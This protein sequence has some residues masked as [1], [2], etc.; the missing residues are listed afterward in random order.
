MP[1]KALLGGVAL[2][3]VAGRADA[4]ESR[5]RFSIPPK[6]YAD[7]LID[8]GLQAN[9]SI[10]GTSNCGA[11]GRA[12]L[13]GRYRLDEALTRVLAGAPCAYRIVDGRTVRILV[14]LVATPASEAHEVVRASPLVS[15]VLV[16]ATKRP[17]ALD[18]LPAGVSAISHEQMEV[19]DATDVGR[20]VGQLS[21]VLT[22]NLGPGRDK[23]L[24]RGLSDGT[25][26]GRARSTVG[27]YLDDA[28]INYNAPDPDLFLVDVDRV[29]V[30]RGPQGA[31]YGSGAVAGIYRIVTRKP[32]LEHVAAGISGTL[33]TT[34][35]GDGSHEIDGYISLPIVPDRVA[36]RLAAYD[37]L[38]GGYL[39]DIKLG[40]TNV[41]QTRRDGGR[42]AVRMVLND[43]W[44]LD[45]LAATQNLRSNDTQYV[46]AQITPT[47]K[48]P[49][50]EGLTSLVSAPSDRANQVREAHN[51]DFDYGGVT[52]SGD[53]DWGSITSSVSYV[54]HVFSSQYDT[55]AALA[56]TGS[57]QF[58]GAKPTDLGVYAEAA[59]ADMLVQDLVVRSSRQGRFDWLVGVYAARTTER[60]PSTL[61]ILSAGPV[62]SNVYMETRKDRLNE[63]AVYGEG[64][65]DLGQG[66]SATLG[67]RLFA[68]RVHTTATLDVIQPYG[69][70]GFDRSHTF[71]GFS[72]KVSIQKTFA[73]DNLV[74]GLIT[75]GYRP[76]GFNSSGFF[77]I[78]ESRT[79][80]E[81]DRLR[82]YEVG[83]KF[84]AMDGRLT[85]RTAAYYDNWT[86]IQTDRYRTSG[87]AYTANVADADIVGLEGEIAYDW[88]N[89]FS[90][91]LNGLLADSK[92]KNAN[93][94]FNG[95]MGVADKLPGVPR[96]SG[97]LL[98]I[99][100]H[101][102][103][104]KLTLRLVG[105]ASY[106]G[107]A[108]L[109]FDPALPQ[110]TASYLRARLSAEL[111]G[112]VWRL[113]VFVSNPLNDSGDTFAY[114][115]PFTFDQYRQVTPQRPRTVG[116]RLGAAF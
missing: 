10:L 1:L 71:H 77:P 82:N 54:H 67:G 32:D 15:E 68:S 108:G 26:T 116:L 92:V 99:Y 102:I 64:S 83:A 62:V 9:V 90:L 93:P 104:S 22:T 76:G 69:T 31:L 50:E 38:Q 13:S 8:L 70:R 97:G 110:Q 91:Q 113:M 49:A 60:T 18:T 106:V 78:R 85:V 11:G 96:T 27:T 17:A 61:G 20:T 58:L 2:A 47:A 95:A 48:A 5:L 46:S 115:N 101:P 14:K 75:E 53:F 105:Q 44:R 81:P 19:T 36:I 80:F 34:E 72:P 40:M 45:G 114:G 51:N 37:D 43:N 29:E 4:A 42:L 59:R 65:Y 55:T 35:G 107:H 79:T 57:L 25:F 23:F 33:A 39:D 88:S 30:V 52:L 109:T 41:D 103:G 74:Y 63:Y 3:C 98:A 94:D 112:D 84:R 21:G 24:I 7:A 56:S 86:N 89:G 6:P 28:P 100:T 12:Q 111:S 66:W 73:G 87:L 16:T